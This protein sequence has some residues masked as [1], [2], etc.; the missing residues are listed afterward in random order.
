[1]LVFKG[2]LPASLPMY[3][4]SLIPIHLSDSESVP[5]IIIDT[6]SLWML[7]CY[8]SGVQ[9]ASA[10]QPAHLEPA[11]SRY[12]F[13]SSLHVYA[14]VLIQVFKGRLPVNLPIV[15]NPR[16]VCT[17]GQVV[18]DGSMNSFKEL[19]KHKLKRIPCRLELSPK[20]KAFCLWK[21]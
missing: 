10:C 13:K 8:L 17:A 19:G 16:L 11:C 21:I 20:V 6:W 18:D 7:L 5:H 1:M 14:G 2:R 3:G 4:T 15:W 12:D 9:G